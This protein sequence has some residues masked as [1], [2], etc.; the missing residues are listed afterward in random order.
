MAKS[1]RLENSGVVV[2]PVA[3]SSKPDY[4]SVVIQS[5]FPAHLKY[6]GLVTGKLYEWA[7]AGDMV[8]V[9][10]ADVTDLLSKRVGAKGCCGG[11]PDGNKV[12]QLLK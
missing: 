8:S 4:N 12:F 5:I 11:N 10:S 6:R 7:K 3:Q 2:P 1:D 9:D